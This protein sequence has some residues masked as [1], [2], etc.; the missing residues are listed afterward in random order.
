M[1]E[2]RV[3]HSVGETFTTNTNAFKYTVTS[4]LMHNQ[5]RVDDTCENN[6]NDISNEIDQIVHILG[7]G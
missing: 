7:G 3:D 5:V 4:E 1:S 6:G 2:I